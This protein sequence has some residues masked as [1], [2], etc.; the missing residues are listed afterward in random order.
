MKFD[1][2]YTN[3]W[4]STV[5]KSLDGTVI[6]GLNEAKHFL[7]YLGIERPDLILD[8]GCSFGRMH[9]AL[10]VYSDQIFGIDP[11]PYAVEKACLQ[12]YREVRQGSAEH[13]GFGNSYFDVVF[14]WAV[15]DVV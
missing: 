8:L 14:C 15:F 4:S 3:Y 6:A 1:K 2:D 11:D 10:A 12:P 5:N 9:E 13:T 7:Q